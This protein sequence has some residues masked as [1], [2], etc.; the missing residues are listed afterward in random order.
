LRSPRWPRGFAVDFVEQLALPDQRAFREGHLLE[1][2][3]DTGA[4]LDVLEADA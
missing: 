3:L 1:E 4:N 2:A